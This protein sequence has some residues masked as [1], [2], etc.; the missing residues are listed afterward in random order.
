MFTSKNNLHTIAQ[1]W[2][3]I[4]IR[5]FNV[6]TNQRQEF[7]EDIGGDNWM[8]M[9]GLLW[10]NIVKVKKD[11]LAAHFVWIFYYNTPNLVISLIVNS[12]PSFLG[13]RSDHRDNNM[14][15][16]VY[17]IFRIPSILFI[18][19]ELQNYSVETPGVAKQREVSNHHAADLRKG[20]RAAPAAKSTAKDDRKAVSVTHINNDGDN[21]NNGGPAPR[22]VSC[23]TDTRTQNRWTDNGVIARGGVHNVHNDRGAV[24]NVHNDQEGVHNSR[25]AN[26]GPTAEVGETKPNND[27]QGRDPRNEGETNCEIEEDPNSELETKDD[28]ANYELYRKLFVRPKDESSCSDWISDE[29][30][31]YYSDDSFVTIH[32]SGE[33]TDD[34]VHYSDTTS[35]SAIGT[36]SFCINPFFT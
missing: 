16:I 14:L 19:P 24:H 35:D 17:F 25:P 18:Q 27:D 3:P 30:E 36:E 8:Q 9:I 26:H 1:N 4:Y 20:Y 29:E 32:S 2:W 34:T 12:Q 33:D 13:F 23:L 10:T 15:K 6:S 7:C 31:S 22:P 21:N 11:G 5:Q 28:Q